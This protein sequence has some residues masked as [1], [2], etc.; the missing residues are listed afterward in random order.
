LYITVIPHEIVPSARQ[1]VL[2][3]LVDAEAMIS[4]KT[5]DV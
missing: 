2:N 1:N 3:A 4:E 5:F